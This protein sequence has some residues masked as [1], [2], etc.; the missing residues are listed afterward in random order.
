[1][2][3]IK[4][5]LKIPD[6]IKNLKKYDE[7]SKHVRESKLLEVLLFTKR[8]IQEETHQGSGPIHLRDTEFGEIVEYGQKKTVGVLGVYGG[9]ARYSRSVEYGTR[10]YYLGKKVVEGPL[11]FWVEKVLGHS[12]KKATQVAWAIATIFADVGIEGHHMFQYG[13]KDSE[14]ML[15]K[16]LKQIPEEIIRQLQHGYI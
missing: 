13:I 4:T 15:A 11:K 8:K 16:I 10:P 2:L 7:I 3:N 5:K 12:G 6:S 1:M 9:T 14:Y